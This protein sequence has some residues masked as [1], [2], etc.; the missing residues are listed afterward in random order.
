MKHIFSTIV[1]LC[2]FCG[3]NKTIAQANNIYLDGDNYITFA[4]VAFPGRLDWNDAS[5][6]RITGEENQFPIKTYWF[7]HNGKSYIVVNLTNGKSDLYIELGANKSSYHFPADFNYS[8]KEGASN[9]FLLQ[10]V[11]KSGIQ[12]GLMVEKNTKLSVKILQLD[13]LHVKLSFSG[14][15]VPYTNSNKTQL[16]MRYEM[17]PVAISGKVS[18]SK[19]IPGLK[20][21]PDS[22]S[23][24]D[25]SIYNQLSPDYKW[26]QY[27]TATQ[28]EESFYK[29]IFTALTSALSPAI[30]YLASKD[31]YMQDMPKYKPL[32]M[33]LRSET[34]HFFRTDP[35]YGIDYDMDI[36][37]NQ[38]KGP[39][40]DLLQKTKEDIMLL[41]KGDTSKKKEVDSIQEEA[42]EKFKL[43]LQATFNRRVL[44]DN[45]LNVSH[46]RIKKINDK[47]FLIENVQNTDNITF[48]DDG[49]TYLFVGKWR[50][51]T[52][53][54]GH[55]ICFPI[56]NLNAKKLSIQTMY[57]R[58]GCGNELAETLIKHIDMD[59]LQQILN[60]SP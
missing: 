16:E 1:I 55:I 22:Y 59:K 48:H 58:F 2:L 8:G 26:G 45:T 27:Y 37:A 21:L 52:F 28:C 32:E 50:T 30:N 43:H 11:N 4:N 19:K 34:E 53:E 38:L 10:V 18:L 33:R 36:T 60:V 7:S 40:Y 17:A 46:A 9:M 51:P 12:Q 35:N 39:Y 13:S 49:G 44:T 3:T 6:E 54:N 14:S 25:N 23:G 5:R 56:F 57:I 41:I 20:H 31:W 47:V 15:I 24:C 29:N 42:N